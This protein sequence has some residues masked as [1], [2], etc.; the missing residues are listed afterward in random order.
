MGII[1][2]SYKKCTH[3]LLLP[4]VRRA[5][6]LRTFF[7][8]I[9]WWPRYTADMAL[10]L[11]IIL[12]VFVTSAISGVLGMAGGMIL[13][14]CLVSLLPVATAIIIHAAAQFVANGSRA[15]LHRQ[16]I[17]WP[18]LRFYTMGLVCATA[19]MTMIAFVPDKATVFL[20]LG[21]LP[22]AQLAFAKKIHLNILKPWQGLLCGFLSTLLHLGGGVA[23]MLID[24]FFQRTEMTRHQII[25]TK[26]TTQVMSHTVR[27]VYF[28]L[29]A[30]SFT[31][32]FAGIG[33][34]G[35]AL[36]ALASMTGTALSGRVLDRLSDRSFLRITQTVLLVLGAIYLL[37]GLL[38]LVA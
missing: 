38:L 19:L 22:F 33:I 4:F 29:L 36:I 32:S 18:A 13:L 37:R 7:I 34:T 12:C 21:I 2:I 1:K 35:M 20:L 31:Q 26:A 5:L 28:S 10:S 17:V 6:V 24:V 14:G 9:R 8:L 25:A 30:G 16:H 23:G 3:P 15:I 27:F 11:I